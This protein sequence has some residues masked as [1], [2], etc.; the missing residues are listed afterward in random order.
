MKWVFS[1]VTLVVAFVGWCALAFV[2]VGLAWG[3]VG[4]SKPG[5]FVVLSYFVWLVAPVMLIVGLVGA[6]VTTWSTHR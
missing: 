2:Q 3:L 1:W 4:E 6:V 5:W